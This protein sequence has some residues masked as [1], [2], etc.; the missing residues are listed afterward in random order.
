MI[1]VDFSACF[2]RLNEDDLRLSPN[3]GLYRLQNPLFTLLCLRERVRD[4]E[5]E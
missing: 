5:K 2:E 1:S 3:F 4:G